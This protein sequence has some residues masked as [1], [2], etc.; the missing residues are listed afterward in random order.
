MLLLTGASGFFGKIAYLTLSK[1]YKTI[2]LSF[3]SNINPEFI[4]LSPKIIVHSAACRDP[5]KCETNPGFAFKLNVESTSR[6]SEWCSINNAKLVYISTDYVFDG[7]SPPYSEKDPPNPVSLYGKSKAMGEAAAA[8]CENSIIVRMPL[9]Y[10]FSMP[11][12]DSFLL[13]VLKQFE[14]GQPS[15]V[16]DFQVR[17]P[18]LSDDVALAIKN[19]LQIDYSGIIHLSGPT[20]LT[21]Y[22]MWKSIA[23]VFNY[24]DSL[25]LRKKMPETKEAKRPANSRLN[26]SL[27]ES[28]C[29]HKFR[30]F[31]EGLEFSKRLR[32]IWFS[33]VAQLASCGY[34]EVAR[35]GRKQAVPA[36]FPFGH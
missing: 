17:F 14:T 33:Q 2:G 34:L 1:C 21:R 3:S 13:K 35:K 30:T 11:E 10:G 16:D 4:K 8:K 18:T 36:C 25:V 12:K 26:T 6:I 5:D 7:T 27:Y 32:I 31:R 28:L 15:E 9:Q 20:E 23:E 24:P 22:S 19:L 29:G